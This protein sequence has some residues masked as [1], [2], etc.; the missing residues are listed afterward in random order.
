[1]QQI[2]NIITKKLEERIKDYNDLQQI[3]NNKSNNKKEKQIHIEHKYNEIISSTSKRTL[4]IK[5]ETLDYASPVENAMLKYF[6]IL[7]KKSK[8]YI[9]EFISDPKTE[10]GLTLISIL[11]RCFNLIERKNALLEI[12]ETN[13]NLLLQSKFVE[14]IILSR[15]LKNRNREQDIDLN[16]FNEY[17]QAIV[18][19][20][21]FESQKNKLQIGYYCIE[22]LKEANL[23]TIGLSANDNDNKDTNNDNNM[24]V[25]KKN[26]KKY[27]TQKFVQLTGEAKKVMYTIQSTAN[28]LPSLTKPIDFSVSENQNIS[29]NIP[30]NPSLS[31]IFTNFLYHDN[32]VTKERIKKT[33]ISIEACNA[34]NML[35]SIPF[36]ISNITLEYIIQNIDTVFSNFLDDNNNIETILYDSEK[37]YLESLG[38]ILNNRM[39]LQYIENYNRVNN[40]LNRFV[41]ILTFAVIY[42]D[43]PFYYNWFLCWR[44][45]Y[46]TTGFPLT[47]QGDKICRKLLQFEEDRMSTMYNQIINDTTDK[48]IPIKTDNHLVSLDACAS[49]C[50]IIGF[51][52]GSQE[53]LEQ[54][55]VFESE[56]EDQQDIYNV[57]LQYFIEEFKKTEI[58]TNKPEIIGIFTRKFYKNLIMCRIYSEGNHSRAKK[59]L[60]ELLSKNILLKRQEA[61][62][63]ANLVDKVFSEKN[64][65]IMKFE[66][67]MTNLCKELL[68]KDENIILCSNVNH[69]KTCVVYPRQETKRI[70]IKDIHGKPKKI[71]ISV[72]K[73]PMKTDK[74]KTKNAFTPNFIHQIDALIVNKVLN[75]YKRH[76]SNPKIFSIHD[77][78]YVK[79]N[80]SELIKKIY[81]ETC[82]EIFTGNIENHPLWILLQVNDISITKKMEEYIISSIEKTKRLFKEKKMSKNILK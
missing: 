41:E 33:E 16:S 26:S 19:E 78:F 72:N 22:C 23:L 81:Y 70:Q 5:K 74:R 58:F 79:E 21:G 36:Y 47:P 43:T 68:S 42:K 40:Y 56:I 75:K 54:T 55:F 53:I 35:Q 6:N 10:H 12:S 44:G 17:K 30:N 66:L 29:I 62:K 34:V 3:I 48:I 14:S 39:R 7:P 24:S 31:G 76:T 27:K 2:K 60:E 61:M 77:C 80:E 13:L 46:H 4:V 25:Y 64:K 1:M 65:D 9:N 11:I 37:E 71:S 51:L 45:R 49:G 50:Q 69:V 8:L 32:D 20:Y 82:K 57:N 38:K 73:V 59:I 15:F 63:I 52:T 18:S 28:N 67:I